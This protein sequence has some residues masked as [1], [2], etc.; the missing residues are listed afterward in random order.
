VVK[1][2]RKS[3]RKALDQLGWIV[4]EDGQRHTCRIRDISQSGARLGFKQPET[5]PDDFVL[6][7]SKDGR[8]A[9]HCLMIWRRRDQVG[10][11]FVGSQSTP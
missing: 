2:K 4:T 8:V 9:R 6:S 11:E 5:L 1:E 3:L 10:V 7:L